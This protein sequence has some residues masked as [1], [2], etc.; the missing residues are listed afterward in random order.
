[1]DYG[2]YKFEMVKREKEAKKNQKVTEL[3]EVRLSMTID[4]HDLDV[5]VK[6]ARKFITAGDKVKVSIRMRGRQQA[7][8]SIGVDVM[9]NFF[10]LVEDI[11][12]VDK[13]P[14]TEGRNILM[15][16]TPIKK[17]EK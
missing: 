4:K 13:K 11:C 2:K 5:K 12:T 14:T 10:T 3:K 8:S 6:S 7:H 16:L 17:E 9:N 1:M 15:I